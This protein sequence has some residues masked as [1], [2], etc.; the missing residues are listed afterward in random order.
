MAERL[1]AARALGAEAEEA[2]VLSTQVARGKNRGHLPVLCT[3]L[4]M[5]VLHVRGM[6]C[7]SQRV[8]IQGLPAPR[9]PRREVRGGHRTG[10]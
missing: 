1:S 9:F 3:K 10:M 2:P 8:P 7:S 5:R 4:E 6:V